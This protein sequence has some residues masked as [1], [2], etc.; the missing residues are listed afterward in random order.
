MK[1]GKASVPYGWGGKPTY[2]LGGKKGG[3]R[4]VVDE[5]GLHLRNF[6]PK[7]PP[8]ASQLK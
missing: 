1:L 5:R 7:H 4:E 2:A 6:L 8:E 3:N